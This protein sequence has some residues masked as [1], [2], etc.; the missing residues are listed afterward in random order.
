[1]KNSDSKPASFAD[2]LLDWWDLHGRKDLPW[3]RDRDPYHVWV[4]EIMLQQTQAQTVAGYYERFIETFP[5]ISALAQAPQD[6]VLH[7]WA[8]LGYYARARNLHKAAQQLEAQH[9]GQMPD[10]FDAIVA[11]P[12]IG[13]STAGAIASFCFNQRKPILDGNVKRVLARMFKVEGWPGRTD[14]AKRLWQ[15]ADDLTPT[16]R[17]ADYT[18]AIMDLGATVC[19]R[20]RPLCAEC[21]L[22]FRCAVAGSDE[23]LRYPGRKPRKDLPTRRAKALIVSDRRGRLLLTKRPPTGIW[24]G[25]WSFPECA[26]DENE[27]QWFQREYGLAVKTQPAEPESIHVFSHYRL[28]LTPIPATISSTIERVADDAML[29]WYDP[30]HPD[31]R[32]L[33][34]PVRR[35]ISTG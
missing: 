6:A 28:A 21:P 3:Q 14:V 31:T 22:A 8:G 19:I 30:A 35:L 32:G 29:E 15:L 18:Q 12:G 24:G 23:A 17:V 25:L 34:A 26:E 1:M 27:Q 7:H 9:S 2:S 10:E 13:R 5:S 4:S 33:A 20:T 11:L 16:Q